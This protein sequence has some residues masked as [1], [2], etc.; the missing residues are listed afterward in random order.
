M[1]RFS[2]VSSSTLET[3]SGLEGLKAVALRGG[4]SSQIT[5]FLRQAI[6][7]MALVPGTALTEVDVASRARHRAWGWG[8]GG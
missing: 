6:V 1:A 4:I 2:A 8:Q 7:E 5:G 3:I